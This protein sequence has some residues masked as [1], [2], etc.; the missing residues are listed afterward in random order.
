[1]KLELIGMHKQKVPT[2]DGGYKFQ[3]NAHLS[4]FS[5]YCWISIPGEFVEGAEIGDE[6]TLRLERISTEGTMPKTVTIEQ[7]EASIAKEQDFKIGEKTTVVLLTLRNGFEVVGTSACV[8]AAGYDH[9]LGKKY[10]RERAI[11][12]VWELE[13]YVLQ[14]TLET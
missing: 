14:S 7:V 6:F 1:M 12:K 10:A 9:E 5:P 8:D 2:A 3:V 4:T 13:A 11:S